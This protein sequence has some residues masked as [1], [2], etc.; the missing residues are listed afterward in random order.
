MCKQRGS[1]VAKGGFLVL[2]RLP[3]I[4][5]GRGDAVIA[6]LP[7]FCVIWFY[8]GNGV[9]VDWEDIIIWDF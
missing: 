7:S 6:C 3:G 9:G 2:A 1:R 5:K 4:F 8:Y